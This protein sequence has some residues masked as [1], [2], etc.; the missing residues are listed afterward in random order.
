MASSAV[1]SGTPRPLQA[2]QPGPALYA[3][4]FPVTMSRSPVTG[5]PGSTPAYSEVCSRPNDLPSAC[6]SRATSAA[7]NGATALVP[8]ITLC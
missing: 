1:P 2:S 8:P 3:P 4:L 7:H 6:A 5:A